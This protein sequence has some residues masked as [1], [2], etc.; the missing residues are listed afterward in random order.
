MNAPY[1]N[2]EL[3]QA[4]IRSALAASREGRSTG[5]ARLDQVAAALGRCRA[6]SWA[7]CRHAWPELDV[8]E[9]DFAAEMA[10]DVLAS[11]PALVVL[12][13]IAD[14]ATCAAEGGAS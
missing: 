7:R 11:V 10:V 4:E 13:V 2:V 3:N 8:A 1:A 12:L 14:A 5:S 6:G 9:I